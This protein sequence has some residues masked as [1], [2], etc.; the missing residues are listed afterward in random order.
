MSFTEWTCGQA[1]L[2]F[3]Y[4]SR[5][6]ANIRNRWSETGRGWWMV[7][8]GGDKGLVRKRQSKYI[9]VR[10]W[11]VILSIAISLRRMNWTSLYPETTVGCLISDLIDK[12]C[13]LW[14]SFAWIMDVFLQLAR[15]TWKSQGKTAW[16]DKSC[17][18]FDME[19]K[20]IWILQPRRHDRK[21]AGRML[22]K[23]NC[24][25]W[26]RSSSVSVIEPKCVRM[27]HPRGDTGQLKT[28]IRPCVEH[29]F[30]TF[31]GTTC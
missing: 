20:W 4:V 28:D 12:A 5:A 21:C 23:R 9:R 24:I 19:W 22:E 7:E 16:T 30:G 15:L 29:V 18:S 11:D 1:L 17:R 10:A 13:V 14:F 6:E 25:T 31:T 3:K 26:V 2:E 27:L 8:S